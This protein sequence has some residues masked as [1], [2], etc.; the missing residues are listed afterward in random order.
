MEQILGVADSSEFSLE[1]I[2]LHQQLMNLGGLPISYQRAL[3]GGDYSEGV[4]LKDARLPNNS[5]G[6]RVGMAQEL[7]HQEMIMLQ[8]A[9]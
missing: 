9:K 3:V 4:V 7:L 1:Q 6:L 5:R 8:Y 2:L